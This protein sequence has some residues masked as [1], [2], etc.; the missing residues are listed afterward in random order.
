M[1]I[2]K[3]LRVSHAAL[4]GRLGSLYSDLSAGQLLSIAAV[5]NLVNTARNYLLLAIGVISSVGSLKVALVILVFGVAVS[6]W[7]Y[8]PAL[9]CGWEVW[10]P[11]ILFGVSLGV[12]N[13][14]A[15]YTFE[16]ISPQIVA[17]LGF[18]CAVVFMMCFD[19]F[20][21]IVKEVRKGDFSRVVWPILALPGLWLLVND[22]ADG[23]DGAQVSPGSGVSILGH[24][25][26]GWIPGVAAVIIT[27]FTFVYSQYRLE[28]SDRDLKEKIST[29]SGIPAIVIVAVG[30]SF[31]DGGWKGMTSEIW[32]SLLICAVAGV[33]AGLSNVLVIEAYKH[34]LRAPAVVMLQPLFTLAGILLGCLVERTVPG[35]QGW[36]GIVVIIVATYGDAKYQNRRAASRL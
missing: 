15:L 33:V 11:A 29:L 12:N 1:D 22:S 19:G 34:D 25:I 32:S 30:A 2:E 14:A 7:W 21:E 27:A 36:L 23:K 35:L 18:L 20:K 4:K 16:W 17:P 6:H 13:V 28:V 3:P 9:R 26:A 5:V 8:R 24:E 31:L 10:G